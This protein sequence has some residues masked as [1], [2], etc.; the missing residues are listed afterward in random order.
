MSKVIIHLH[1]QIKQRIM[2]LLFKSSWCI[3]HTLP[4][5]EQRFYMIQEEHRS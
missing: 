2:N 1:R 5:E 3:L 4:V